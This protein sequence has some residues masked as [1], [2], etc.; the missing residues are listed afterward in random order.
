LRAYERS[1]IL[2]RSSDERRVMSEWIFVIAMLVFMYGI[3]SCLQRRDEHQYDL[4]QLDE[5]IRLAEFWNDTAAAERKQKD[6]V[7]KIAEHKNWRNIIKFELGNWTA[8]LIGA[9]ILLV[10]ALLWFGEDPSHTW[11]LVWHHMD[12]TGIIV[13]LGLAAYW[14]YH[15]NKR[16]GKAESEIGWLNRMLKVVK[17]HAEDMRKGSIE[18]YL[19]TKDLLDR[20]EGKLIR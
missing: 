17:D 14:V 4:A 18:N 2:V 10:A 9:A 13:P 16:L 15:L 1:G 3:G 5:E 7:D 11:G 20:L 19:K 12:N 6:R 8:F